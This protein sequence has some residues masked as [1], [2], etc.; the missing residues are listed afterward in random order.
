MLPSANSDTTP[1]SHAA[2]LLFSSFSLLVACTFIFFFRYDIITLEHIRPDNDASPD[3]VS[4]APTRGPF[5]L[6]DLICPLH[7]P[8]YTCTWINSD[9]LHICSYIHI[10]LSLLPI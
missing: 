3:R 8:I 9:H 4:C 2:L 7:P 10:N 5:Y 6:N 1:S